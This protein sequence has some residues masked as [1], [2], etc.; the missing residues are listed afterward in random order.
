MVPAASG[1]VSPAPP[2][3][4]Y[5]PPGQACVYGAVTRYGRTFQCVPLGLARLAQALQPQGAC[6]LVWAVPLSLATTCGIT[7]VFS[8]S[9]YLDVSVPRVSFHAPMYSARDDRSSTCRVAPFGNPR[10]NARSQ[11]PVAYRNV[12]RPSSPLGSKASTVCPY[13]LLLTYSCLA[14]A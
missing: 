2:Y 12:L 5:P 11:L 6:P 8:S 1:R 14:I 4:G 7:V 10:I 13:L 3:S 9:G